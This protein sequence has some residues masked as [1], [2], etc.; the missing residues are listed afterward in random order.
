VG[1]WEWVV[2]TV[3]KIKCGNVRSRVVVVCGCKYIRGRVCGG[4]RAPGGGFN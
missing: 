4:V 1:E 3:V 2:G